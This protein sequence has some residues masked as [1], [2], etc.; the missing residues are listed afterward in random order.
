MKFEHKIIW[1]TGASSGIGKALAIELSKMNV[2]LI[3]SSRNET[4]LQKVKIECA[5][6]H[7]IRII[8]LDLEKY[9]EL[10]S[11]VEEAI[12]LFGKIDI[13]FNN[14][15]ISQ[16]SKA[17]DTSIEVDKKI[18]AINYFGTVA[19]SKALLPHF[20]KQNSGQFVVI[21]SVVGKVATPVRSSYS[22][23]KHALHGFFDSLRAETYQY[24]IKVTLALPGYVKTNIS[25][26]ALTGDGAAQ[27]KMDIAT[28]NGLS[29]EYF[30]KA[31]LKA[32]KKEKN[33]IYIAGFREKS[34]IYLKRF[35][36]NILAKIIRKMAVT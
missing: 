13:L 4:E 32:V 11:K 25:M 21:T 9:H 17:I 16:R 33:E 27:N 26:N 12:A 28:N 19:L 6:S 14:G 34:A 29:P 22:A 24:N 31:L 18:M 35:F 2:K 23:S 3:L 7:N 10:P 30:V 20:I 8:A 36:P 1:I 15:G 5:N